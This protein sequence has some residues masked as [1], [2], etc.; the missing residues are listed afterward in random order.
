MNKQIFKSIQKTMI[1]SSFM[2]FYFPD[3]IKHSFITEM[4]TFQKKSSDF[5]LQILMSKNEED[6]KKIADIL[7]KQ[8]KLFDQLSKKD[9]PDLNY[10]FSTLQKN[11]FNFEFL[12]KS[13]ESN[14]KTMSFLQKLRLNL[15]ISIPEQYFPSQSIKDSIFK[16]FGFKYLYVP[17]KRLTAFQSE[18]GFY[19]FIEQTNLLMKQ[20]SK[21][22]KS[23]SL[24]GELGVYLETSCALYGHKPKC[25][26]FTCD[27]VAS[28]LLH[29]WTHAIDNFIFQKL[30]GIND[31]ASEN[32]E[33]FSIKNR[34][35]LP[36]YEAIKSVLFK[37]CNNEK[38]KPDNKHQVIGDKKSIYYHN[39]LIADE[40]LFVTPNNY[41]HKPCE[42][43]ARLTE[44][45]E[46]PEYTEARNKDLTN[47]VYLKASQNPYKELKEIFFSVADQPTFKITEIRELNLKNS[48]VLNSI[49]KN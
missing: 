6:L 48:V 34:N 22:K 20:M 28:T 49:P 26:G 36:A 2:D 11:D 23:I 35:F 32:L 38:E 17:T 37:V 42:I 30:S 43:L 25:I 5:R 45:G 12:K 7:D 44:S 21:P 31:Y 15:S 8:L 9:F 47:L 10:F 27:I 40:D 1:E 3:N 41:Y 13:R 33:T 4:Q 19:N 39:C 18:Q 46:F 14:F 16:D 24:N 29:E